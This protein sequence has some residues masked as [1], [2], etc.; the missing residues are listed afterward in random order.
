MKKKFIGLILSMFLITS[1]GVAQ[2]DRIQERIKARRIAF[3]TEKLQLTPEEAQLF[4]PIYNDYQKKRRA[5]DKTYKS[6][7][8]FNLMT[9]V[10]VTLH[11]DQQLEKEAK[12]LT[13]KKEFIGDLKAVF[14]IRKVAMLPRAEKKFKE[15]MLAQ[16][17]RRNAG[18]RG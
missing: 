16:I 14:P 4:W 7:A 3:I 13:L 8:N 12:M 10:E 1:I 9:D 15:W 11:V 6:K 17:K 5:F 2:K 18:N